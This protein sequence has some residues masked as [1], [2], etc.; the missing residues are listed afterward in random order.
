MINGKRVEIAGPIFVIQGKTADR[1]GSTYFEEIHI[2]QGGV[3]LQMAWA[4]DNNVSWERNTAITLVNGL[5]D[6]YNSR[7]KQENISFGLT[8]GGSFGLVSLQK[9]PST[10]NMQWTVK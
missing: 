4:G 7:V 6:L 5:T 2:G 8:V 3:V 10:G 9:G 1:N